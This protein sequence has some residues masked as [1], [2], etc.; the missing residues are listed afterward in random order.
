MELHFNASGADR[1]KL[2]EAISKEL[3][4]KAKYLGMPS[5]AYEIGSYTVS[6]DGCLSFD[7]G[8]DIAESSR[9]V[10]AC[11]MAGFEPEEWAQNTEADAPE[12]EQPKEA[13]ETTDSEDLGLTVAMPRE[14]F[15]EGQLE[16]LQKLV[17]AKAP[18]LKAALLVDDLPIEITDEKVSFPWFSGG[19]DAEH[20]GAYTSLITAICKMAKEA[21]RVIAKEKEAVNAKYEFRC[22]LLRLGFIGDEFKINRKL[23][24]ENLSGSSAFKSGAKKGGEA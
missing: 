8:T 14:S 18:L 16:N 23:L 9:V 17:E 21:K 12:A 24:L 22:F 15:T 20:C 7:D 10:D 2:V 6:K 4:I 19:I 5:V 1:K 3:N 11:V 13:E